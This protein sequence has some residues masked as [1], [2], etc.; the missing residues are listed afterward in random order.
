MKFIFLLFL[1]PALGLASEVELSVTTNKIYYLPSDTI[2][3][4]ITAYNP[5]QDT[6][7]L[8]FGS[9]LQAG[10]YIGNWDSAHE[11]GGIGI[12]THVTIPPGGVYSWYTWPYEHNLEDFPLEPGDYPVVA[13][14]EYPYHD[15]SMPHFITIGDTLQEYPQM[16][17]Y[18][19][20]DSLSMPAHCVLVSYDVDTV[21]SDTST[22]LIRFNL[23]NN[24]VLVLSQNI[25][26][27]TYREVHEFYMYVSDPDNHYD[28]DLFWADDTLQYPFEI[29][30]N[31]WIGAHGGWITLNLA[32]SLEGVP[33]DT[34]SQAIFYDVQAS[35]DQ[36]GVRPSVF[37]LKTYPNPTNTA[38]TI[39]AIIPH[40]TV[41]DLDVYD[42]KGQEVFNLH[43]QPVEHGMYNYVWDGCSS[44]GAEVAAGVYVVHLTTGLGVESHKFVILK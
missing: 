34:F 20:A 17:F 41:L 4:T 38:V 28:I 18:P 25:A 42:M 16:G 26:F 40:N 33:V 30:D 35:V 13:Y 29:S 15:L 6:L 24:Y 37:H 43:N 10:Y 31:Q 21:S 3:I 8:H 39:Q 32:T 5:T 12:P 23:E 14:L 44:G 36:R 11:I 22:Q 9:G 7:V 19:Q 27:G 2:Y 1:I